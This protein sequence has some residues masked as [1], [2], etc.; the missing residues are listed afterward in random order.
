MSDSTSA[1]SGQ[2]PG[3]P[4]QAGTIHP[5]ST[6][7]AQAAAGTTDPIS[8]TVDVAVLQRELAEARREA[9]KHRTDLRRVTDAQLSEAERL[10]RR[11]TELEAEREQ[12]LAREKDRAIR[13]AALEAAAKL[14]FRDPDLA[15]RLI[16]PSA[17][18]TKDDGT[19]KNVERLLAD[20]LAR[21]PYLGRTGV[22]SDFGGGQ[23]GA[24]A[25]GTDMN[26]LIR[27]AA[28]RT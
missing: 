5:E 6:T 23:R 1:T 28:G 4:P 10:Q 8:T 25:S 14:G 20:V 3:A 9:A 13:Y 15:I 16:D 27:R 22:A 11:V 26:S 2:E 17:V 24:S 21:S 12:V 7:Q 18:E 19:P